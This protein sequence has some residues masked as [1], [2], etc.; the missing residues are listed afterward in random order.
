MPA[1]RLFVPLLTMFML[2]VLVLLACTQ[3]DELQRSAPPQLDSPL[4]TPTPTATPP[5][6]VAAIAVDYIAA[7]EGIPPE[8]LQA[9]GEES[10]TFSLLGQSYILVTVIQDQPETF[11]QFQ[12]L[13]DPVTQEVEPDVVGVRAAE[14]TAHQAQYG[15]FD[16]PLYERL[17]TSEDAA[18]L[19]V[20]IWVTETDAADTP[21]EVEAE[22]AKQ[23]PEAAKAL[24]EEGVAWSVDDPEL[25]QEIKQAYAELLA[26]QTAQRVQP[27]VDWLT[28]KG[29]EVD[30]FTGTPSVAATVTKQDILDLAQLECVSQ[31]YLVGHAGEPASDISTED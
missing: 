16:P 17:Q 22:I 5:A 19:Q 1:K 8:E 7:Q 3:L 31:L 11:R 6:D 9:V 29:Y 10:L 25:R 30:A 20:A 4:P 14:R 12:V 27:V 18:L 21:Q 26:A 24:Q 13:V 15:K 28:A 23:Y 2:G